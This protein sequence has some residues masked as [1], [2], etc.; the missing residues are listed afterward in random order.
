MRPIRAALVLTAAAALMLAARTTPRSPDPL[1]MDAVTTTSLRFNVDDARVDRLLASLGTRERIAQILLTYP[2]LDRSGPVHYGGVLFV[3]S[4]LKDMDTA[5]ARVD[6]ARKRARIPPFFAVDMEGGEFN[7]MKHHPALGDMPA[8]ESMAKLSNEEV[9]GWGAKVGHAMKEIGLDM[10]LA[11]VL[12]VAASGHMRKNHRSFSGDPEVVFQKARAFSQ[13]LWSAGVVPI[14]KHFPGYGD[15]AGDTDHGLVTAAW[16]EDKVQAQIDVFRRAV[17]DL[18]GVMMSNVIYQS[19][20]PMPAILNEGLVGEAHGLGLIAVTDDLAIDALATPVGGD[21]A[22]V[23]RRAF[24]AD[25]DLL[26]TTA[27]PDWD[28]GLDYIGI[29]EKL[30]MSDPAHEARLAASCRRVLALKDRL[31][32]L[33]GL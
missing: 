32:M 12:D 3:G 10:N 24:L 31:G 33:E 9:K 22:E 2:Q 1:P 23:I 14:G 30:V 20:G 16:P 5:K 18:G 8:A 11:P 25:N 15:L 6:S 13:G 7:R 4:L 27:P 21:L 17:P 26:L 28:K 29:L 19:R